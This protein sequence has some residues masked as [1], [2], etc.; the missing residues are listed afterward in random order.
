[1]NTVRKR[2]TIQYMPNSVL[3]NAAEEALGWV[4]WNLDRLL[5]YRVRVIIHR[6]A[7]LGSSGGTVF[8][9]E[10]P[11]SCLPAAV[12]ASRKTKKRYSTDPQLIG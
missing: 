12:V 9:L 11:P 7:I 2:L 8:F 6:T 10:G 3:Q 1:M 4:I 5:S